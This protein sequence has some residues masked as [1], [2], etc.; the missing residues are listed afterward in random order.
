MYMYMYLYIQPQLEL[1]WLG[2]QITH[3]IEQLNMHRHQQCTRIH[4]HVAPLYNSSTRCSKGPLPFQSES[5]TGGRDES[6]VELKLEHPYCR[7]PLRG[8]RGEG[9]GEGAT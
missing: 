6:S 2:G 7:H 4:V 8:E 3:T 5:G 9:R 1:G